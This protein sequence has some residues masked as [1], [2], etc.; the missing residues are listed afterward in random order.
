[1]IFRLDASGLLVVDAQKGFTTLCPKELP[2]PV[3]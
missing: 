1:M 3:V 2:V